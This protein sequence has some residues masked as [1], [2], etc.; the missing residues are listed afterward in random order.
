MVWLTIILLKAQIGRN[1]LIKQYLVCDSSNQFTCGNGKCISSNW[2]CDGENDCQDNSDEISCGELLIVFVVT[3]C[4]EFFFN[5][6]FAFV[7]GFSY[8]WEG[9]TE[10]RISDQNECGRVLKLTSNGIATHLHNNKL[11]SY[12]YHGRLNGDNTYK[13]KGADKF[14]HRSAIGFWTVKYNIPFSFGI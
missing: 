7:K 11:G 13:L 8:L 14:L 5:F 2:V 1:N 10:N 12:H 9:I 3:D 6:G 4:W